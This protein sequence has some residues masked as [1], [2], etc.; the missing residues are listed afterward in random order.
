MK[1]NCKS[2]IRTEAK[3]GFKLT[4]IIKLLK[5]LHNIQILIANGIGTHVDIC[6]LTKETEYN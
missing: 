4:I 6:E 5:N 1:V 3:I 2:N